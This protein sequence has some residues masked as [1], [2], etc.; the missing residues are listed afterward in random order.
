MISTRFGTELEEL[1]GMAT[2]AGASSTDLRSPDDDIVTTSTRSC[3]DSVCSNILE[4]VMQKFNEYSEGTL[5]KKRNDVLAMEL[6]KNIFGSF[7]LMHS[8][9]DGIMMSA[10]HRCFNLMKSQNPDYHVHKLDH[11]VFAGCLEFSEIM[12]GEF[13]RANS[14]SIH[15]A[16]HLVYH[17][18]L[19]IHSEM[20]FYFTPAAT[21]SINYAGLFGIACF[22]CAA[23]GLLFRASQKMID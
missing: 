2:G 7:I 9:R 22:A 13:D 1:P 8:Y 10:I 6:A 20:S 3:C 23:Y 21:I 18:L 11:A 12:I 15:E 16:V 14:E 19:Q 5:P 17:S 4:H